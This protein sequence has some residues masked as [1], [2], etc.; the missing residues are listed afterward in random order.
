MYNSPQ[1]KNAKI[2]QNKICFV[3]ILLNEHQNFVKVRGEY[4]CNWATPESTTQFKWYWKEINN[5]LSE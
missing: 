4:Q 2:V 3:S 5:P 1:N